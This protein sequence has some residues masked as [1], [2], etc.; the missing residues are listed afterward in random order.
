MK[1]ILD[2]LTREEA[3]AVLA[4]PGRR[5]TTGHRNHYRC[6]CWPRD[7]QPTAAS[8]STGVEGRLRAKS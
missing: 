7:D 2:F 3:A 4:I 1:T 8:R 6:P 5:Y